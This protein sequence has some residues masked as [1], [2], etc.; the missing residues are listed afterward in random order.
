MSVEAPVRYFED[1]P[2]GAVFEGGAIPVSEAEILEFARKYD[3]Q[4]MHTD[5]AAAASGFFGGLIASGWHTAG[6]M[7]RLFTAHFLSPASSLASP[8]IDE[9]RWSKPVRPGDVLSIRV[10]VTEARRSRS[11]PEQGVVRSLVEVLNP[12]GEVVMTLKPVSL[13]RCRPV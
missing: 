10:T 4:A 3:P 8:G 5:P 13:I 11:K 6:L 1:Y 9:L 2:P 7:M 12:R